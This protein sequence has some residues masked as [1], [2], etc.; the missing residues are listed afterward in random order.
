MKNTKSLNICELGDELLSISKLK[1]HKHPFRQNYMDQIFQKWNENPCVSKINLL[2][3]PEYY[4]VTFD[5]EAKSFFEAIL[6]RIKDAFGL[7]TVNRRYKI[8]FYLID[9]YLSGR[10]SSITVK[11]IKKFAG[12][13]NNRNIPFLELLEE[14]VIASNPG[15]R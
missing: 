14:K 6:K 10:V 9:D 1:G 11:S 13:L 15:R 7:D 4:R 3:L 12:F 5:E 2:D 8:N